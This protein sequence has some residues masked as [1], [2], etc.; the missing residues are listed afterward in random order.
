[1]IYPELP[2]SSLA[3]SSRVIDECK[4][5]LAVPSLGQLVEGYILIASKG[6]ALNM[7]DLPTQD[8]IEV[9]QFVRKVSDLQRGIYSEPII[10]EHGAVIRATEVGCG[11]DTAHF[12]L[13]PLSDGNFPESVARTYRVVREF[14]SLEDWLTESGS[15]KSPYIMV[16]KL[17]GPILVCDYGKQRISQAVRRILH[18]KVGGRHWDW[19]VNPTLD[20]VERVVRSFSAQNEAVH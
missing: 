19:R 13:V 1:M 18:E 16:G 2:P 20:V 11:L 14:D 3:F 8:R 7:L 6:N 9:A 10:F 5:F 15:V 12:H 4:N 17:N